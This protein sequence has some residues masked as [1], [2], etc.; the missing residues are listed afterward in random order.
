MP[1]D[2]TDDD[3]TIDHA[4]DEIASDWAQISA[5]MGEDEAP[6]VAAQEDT[7]SADD[8]ARDEAG[9]FAKAEKVATDAAKPAE[10]AQDDAQGTQPEQMAQDPSASLA[11]PPSSWTAAGKAKWST[12][13]PEI[14]AEVV[15][16]EGDMAKARTQLIG[17]AEFSQRVKQ[18][19]EPYR[20]LIESEGGTP[21]TAIQ[22]LLQT[23]ALFR[24]GTAEQKAQA[25]AELGRQYGIVPQ[26][27][28][29]EQGQQAEPTQ[30]FRDP[31][32]DQLLGEMNRR[33]QMRVE[34]EKQYRL[35]AADQWLNETDASGQPVRPYAGNVIEEITAL[36]PAIQKANPG[37]S[38]S[39][40]WD[41]AYKQA[42]WANP[43]TQIL[44]LQAHEAKRR[45]DILR[46][47]AEAKKAASVNV[48]RRAGL[49][50]AA[51]LGSLDQTIGEE[52]R[53]LGFIS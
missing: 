33:E 44:Q 3:L 17:E 48:P 28:G 4:D 46:T 49:P 45:E 30:E 23:A 34:Q 43:E 27:Q 50:T 35:H 19:I 29:A 6:A 22:S 39:E 52:A 15:K 5:R 20:M 14:R 47:T 41:K 36:A 16:R 2:G 26:Q 13:P 11:V 25:Y 40:V 51:P 53:R 24:I 7:Q 32:V 38:L 8:R 9:R 37:L 10:A 12:L 1:L 18:V 31:R 21:E 42:V